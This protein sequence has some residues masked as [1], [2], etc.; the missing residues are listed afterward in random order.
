MS[1]IWGDL[2]GSLW[3]IPGLMALSAVVLA[4]TLLWL[5]EWWAP[6][7]AV[8]SGWIYSRSAGGARDLL[9]TIAASMITIAGLTFSILVVALQLASSQFGPRVLRNYMRDRGSQFVLGTFIATF[10][11]CLM[12]MRTIGDIEGD[13]PR[14]A[15]SFSVVLAVASLAVLIYFLHHSAASIHAPNVIAAVAHE[16]SASID[17]MYPATVGDPAPQAWAVP[18]RPQQDELIASTRAGYVQRV[19]GDALLHLAE[20]HDAVFH[21]LRRP[22]DFVLAGQPLVS[23]SS[24]TALSDE[25]QSSALGAFIVGG[26]RTAEQDVEFGF[27]QL[28][29]IALRALSPAY[30]DPLT[31]AACVEHL[32]AAIDRLLQRRE[33]PAVRAGHDGRPRVVASPLATARLIEVVLTPIVESARGSTIVMRQLARTLEIVAARAA[34]SDSRAALA[35]E[36]RVLAQQLDSIISPRARA[37]IRSHCERALALLADP[38]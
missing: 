36:T 8:E 12:V 13:E 5:D 27:E 28:V 25:A 33:P 30:N 17:R 14:L 9:G 20:H 34:T 19:N 22:G 11:Y 18:E 7:W 32:G 23:V 35:A 31:A 24:A 3:F 21:V 10:L 2:R 15:V 29:Q 1:H 4:L 6:A 26:Q 38:E 16:L 37:E